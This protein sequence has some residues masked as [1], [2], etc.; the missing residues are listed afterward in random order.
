MSLHH[1]EVEWALDDGDFLKR[2]YSRVHSLRFAGG[3]TVVGSASVSVVPL[4]FSKA[5]AVD[6]EA[7]FTS[8]LSSCHMLTF[9]DLAS[10]AGFVA[11]AY[12]DK[13]EGELAKNAA[14]RYAVTRVVLRPKIIW[15]GAAPSA[16][17][18]D[19]LHHRAHD[20]CFIANSV[21]AEVVVEAS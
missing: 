13:A 3:I 4:P 19:D 21:T 6:P 7:A 16:S 17:E 12:H 18:L 20:L 11:T 5:D 8:A 1:A 9:L 10:R 2:R 15:S 14:G